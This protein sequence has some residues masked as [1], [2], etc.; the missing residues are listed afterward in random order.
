MPPEAATIGIRFPPS[1]IRFP[2]S[3]IEPIALDETPDEMPEPAAGDLFAWA[4][5]YSTCLG[6]MGV[7][8]GW[9]VGPDAREFIPDFD[10]HD[11]KPVVMGVLWGALAAA[12]MLLLIEGVRRVPL[13]SVQ[14]LEK[15]SSDPVFKQLTSLSA[16]ELVVI[17]LCA[18]VG[19]ELLFRGWLMQFLMTVGTEAQPD[20]TRIIAAIAVSSFVFGLVHPITKLYIVLA[21]V[22]GAYLGL[23]FHF[24]GNLLIPITAHAV[25]DAVQLMMAK[26]FRNEDDETEIADG[27][28]GPE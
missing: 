14:E 3:P 24:S 25:Y 9:L 26:Y 5:I 23:L 20:P 1:G 19:E 28:S 8:L 11:A 7:L 17:S 6:V 2:P 15:L 27:V 21:T 12:P 4:S 18:G 16:L 22:I 13:Q 10:P